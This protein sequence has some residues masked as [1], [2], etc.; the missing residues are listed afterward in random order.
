MNL[1][2]SLVDAGKLGGWI[3]AVVAAGIAAAIAKWPLLKDLLGPEA[4]A[5]IAT[6]AAGIVVGAWSHFAKSES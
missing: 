2:V 6:A 5:A 3:R 1:L 4:Q